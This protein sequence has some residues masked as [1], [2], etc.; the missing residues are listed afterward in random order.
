MTARL[1]IRKRDGFTLVELM[2][3]IVIVVVLASLVFALSKRAIKSANSVKDMAAMRQVYQTL[4]MYA[5]DNNGYFPGPLYTGVKAVYRPS[6]RGRLANYI[7]PYLGY[8]NPS[9]DE[10]LP[11]MAYSWQKTAA[12]RNANCAFIRRDVPIKGSEEETIRPFGHLPSGG[13]PKKMNAVMSQIDPVR[14]WVITDLDQQHPDVI[15]NNPGW[16]NE[17]PEEMSHGVYRLAIYF[18]GHAGKLNVDNEPF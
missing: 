9:V 3:V 18:D 14:S 15:E 5:A 4:P 10:F 13:E 2:V 12:S 17:I 8:E 1:G 11:A 6:S 7:A 16:R